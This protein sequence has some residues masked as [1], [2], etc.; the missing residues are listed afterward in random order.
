MAT[1]MVHYQPAQNVTCK[2]QGV[3]TAGTFV[4]IAETMDGRNPVVKT[5]TAGKPVF[6][7]V[8]HD[9]EAKGHVMVYR[10]GH[11]LD[12]ASTGSIAAGDEIAAGANGKATKAI[13]SAKPVGIA[14]T[15]SSRANI[16]TVALY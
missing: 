15:A 10:S 16:V 4:E 2:A 5:A 13:E 3:L 1:T 9:V 14:L 12:V 11:I 7:V 8:A 6:G